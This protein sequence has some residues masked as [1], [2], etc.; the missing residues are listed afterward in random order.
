[1]SKGNSEQSEKMESFDCS[2]E[3]N[4]VS[5]ISGSVMLEKKAESKKEL[6]SP[7]KKKTK[8]SY[9][10][11]KITFTVLEGYNVRII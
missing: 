7:K 8:N 10:D 5:V 11:N 6:I 9:L 1:M 2:M 3:Q 4:D